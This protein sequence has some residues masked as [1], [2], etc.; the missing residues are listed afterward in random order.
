MRNKRVVFYLIVAV[1]GD[2]QTISGSSENEKP[3]KSEL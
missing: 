2:G 3:G 1:M